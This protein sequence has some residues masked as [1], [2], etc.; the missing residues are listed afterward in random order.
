M[1]VAEANLCGA[2]MASVAVNTL[3]TLH[4]STVEDREKLLSAI[5]NELHPPSTVTQRIDSLLGI[6]TMSNNNSCNE[7]CNNVIY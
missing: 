4:I 3:D 6:V 1:L 7:Q 5:Y 2:D